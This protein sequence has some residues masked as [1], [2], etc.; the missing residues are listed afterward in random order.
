MDYNDYIK[1]LP[2]ESSFEEPQS[3][4]I[5]CIDYPYRENPIKTTS[6]LTLTFT[7]KHINYCYTDKLWLQV[8]NTIDPV[9]N[10]YNYSLKNCYLSYFKHALK[11]FIMDRTLM[12]FLTSRRAYAI[13]EL[14]DK[15]KVEI[16]RK[17]ITSLGYFLSFLLNKKITLHEEQ[18]EWTRDLEKSSIHL[19]L[20]PIYNKEKN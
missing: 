5:Q 15:P 10:M 14:L 3:K 11:E 12:R 4:V 2:S 6:K 19:T 7:Q 1:R 18:F 16:E 9:F 20:Y 17:H 8:L 13:L